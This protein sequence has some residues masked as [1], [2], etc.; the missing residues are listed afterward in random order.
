MTDVLE[1]ASPEIKEKFSESVLILPRKEFNQWRKRNRIPRFTGKLAEE[2]TVIRR[3]LRARNYTRM[4]RQSEVNKIRIQN[5]VLRERE[6]ELKA[7]IKVMRALID[8]IEK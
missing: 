5:R 6:R 4:K 3:R 8:S 7:N 1:N 2:L